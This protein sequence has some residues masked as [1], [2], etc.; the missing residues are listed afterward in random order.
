[1]Q[2]TYDPQNQGTA[3]GSAA[4]Q[5]ESAASALHARANE[6]P[7]MRDAA[8]ATADKMRRAAD[9]IRENDAGSMWAGAQRTVG[10]YPGWSLLTAAAFGFILARLI[11]R[12]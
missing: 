2:S 1:M 11:S 12:D 6:L 9:Y 3:R 10:N 4:D 7:G 5:L 8:H